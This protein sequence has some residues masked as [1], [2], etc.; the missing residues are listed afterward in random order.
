MRL[1]IALL[2]TCGVLLA[3]GC[4]DSE[5]QGET[6]VGETTRSATTARDPWSSLKASAG[7][8]ANRLAVI[9]GPPP[10]K[11]VIRDLRVGTGAK[12]QSGDTL[13]AKYKAF[14]YENGRLKESVW[15]KDGLFVQPWGVKELVP[16]WEIGLE[17]MRVGGI[18]QLIVPSKFAYESGALVYLVRLIDVEAHIL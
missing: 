3:A 6:R 1:F 4:G 18:R 5:T 13:T 10:A 17:G 2:L 16:G 9:K 14:H 12:L 15:G 8:D 11:V 7:P